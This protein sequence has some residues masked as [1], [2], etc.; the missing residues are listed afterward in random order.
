MTA[1]HQFEELL[2][3]RRWQ[4]LPTV[5][6]GRCAMTG[7]ENPNEDKSASDPN[8]HDPP[9]VRA[10]VDAAGGGGEDPPPSE[11]SNPGT[12]ELLAHHVAD[13][14]NSKTRDDTISPQGIQSQTH[15]EDVQH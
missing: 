4:V 3:S 8:P 10:G 11:S 12:L 9:V 15:P 5:S 1:S 13:L 7:G 6:E 14:K 2:C